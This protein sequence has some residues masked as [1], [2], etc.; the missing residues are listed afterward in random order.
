VSGAPTHDVSQFAGQLFV[1]GWEDGP[2]WSATAFH[3]VAVAVRPYDGQVVLVDG[4]SARVRAIRNG[5]MDT[6]AGGQR[7]GTVDGEGDLAGFG[8]PRGVAIA[9]DGSA[10]VVDWKEH[11]LRRVTGF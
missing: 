3:T 7:A 2:P 1:D 4:A 9:P 6:L 8:T 11:A 5:N 10:Y